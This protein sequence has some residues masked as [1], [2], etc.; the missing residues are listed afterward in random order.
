[1]DIVVF[2]LFSL[3]LSVPPIA[4]LRYNSIASRRE[5]IKYSYVVVYLRDL[6]S[7]HYFVESPK[8]E[9]WLW[10]PGGIYWTIEV[11]EAMI[12]IFYFYVIINLNNDIYRYVSVH[13]TYFAIDI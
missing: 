11:G 10:L 8:N 4:W 6:L 5:I 13:H 9:I 7:R 2:D 3:E 1:M 12:T